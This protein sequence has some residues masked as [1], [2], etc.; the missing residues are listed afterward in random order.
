MRHGVLSGGLLRNL[1]WLGCVD[2]VREHSPASASDCGRTPVAGIDWR[3]C[4][5]KNLMLQG[6]DFQGANL[7][8]TDLS[9]TNLSGTNL[10]SAE[11]REGNVGAGVVH[12]SSGR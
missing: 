9:L 7:A 5:K 11:S 6:S 10:T 2:A 3:E 8:G 12:G 4:S 1:S